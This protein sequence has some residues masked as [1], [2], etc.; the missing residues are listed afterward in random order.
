VPT[1]KLMKMKGSEW[2][3]KV[4]KVDGC[5]HMHVSILY[6]TAAGRIKEWVTNEPKRGILSAFSSV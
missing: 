6:I 2:P 5:Y 1:K 4:R 3:S